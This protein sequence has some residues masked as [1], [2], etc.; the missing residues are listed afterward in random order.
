M[1]ISAK[2]VV[3]LRKSR[4]W[5]Q[6]KLASMSGLNLRT[7]QRVEREGVA[8]NKSKI[9]IAEA[10]GV[11][12]SEL[13]INTSSSQYEFKVLEIALDRNIALDLNNPLVLELST[14]LNKHGQAGWKLAQI[15]VPEAIMGS[16]AV[17]SHKLLAVMQR[18]IQET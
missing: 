5:S 12:V 1:K 13:Y 16:F 14:E 8:S 11:N 7:I 4:Y 15:M 9:A 2:R 17:P 6:S 3:E 18:E 10:L